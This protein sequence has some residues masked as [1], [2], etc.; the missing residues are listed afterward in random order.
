MSGR[1]QAIRAVVTGR[2][3]G[4][5]FRAFARRAALD[6]DLVGWVR[7]AADGTVELA[8]AGPVQALDAF[9]QALH[10]G[11]PFSR[12]DAVDET[13]IEPASLDCTTF[14]VRF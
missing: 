9:R 4:V 10:Q 2:V 3:Q 1:I 7:N 13:P 6:L 5:G 14:E 12:V 11:P 8:A